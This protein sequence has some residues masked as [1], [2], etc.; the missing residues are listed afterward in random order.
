MSTRLNDGRRLSKRRLG[1]ELSRADIRLLADYRIFLERKGLR[2]N[3]I[4]NFLAKVRLFA[5]HLFPRDLLSATSDDVDAFID[6]RQL[7]ARARYHY[8]STIHG[9]FEWAVVYGHAKRD[10]TLRV[11]RPRFP[12]SIP[13]PIPDGDLRQLIASAPQRELAMIALAAFHGLRAGEIAG[14][15]RE[16]ILELNSPPVL[17][18][19]AGKGG[20]QRVLPLHT[21][22]WEMIRP[23]THGLCG[24]L[25]TT[26]TG[27]PLKPYDVSHAVNELLEALSI[28]A[29]CHSLRH[30]YG[31]KVYRA[32][33]DLR[34]T[35]ALMGHASP[36][37]TVGYVAFSSQD[38][39]EAVAAITHRREVSDDD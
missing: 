39:H 14:L 33:K 10:P 28:E 29:S 5:E 8:V 23:V 9:L 36:N 35:Q 30:W 31:T 18:V 27:R 26:Q 12:R 13:R 11:V 17:I 24:Y 37:T 3:S 25:F 32:S 22:G 7:G 6:G 34:V 16:D 19:S 20:H 4:T 2:P 15:Q 1:L 21:E 38:A